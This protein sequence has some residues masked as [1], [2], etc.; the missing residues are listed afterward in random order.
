MREYQDLNAVLARI[1]S[2]H[3]NEVVTGRREGGGDE[4]E[5][6]GMKGRVW[7]RG[8]DLTAHVQGGTSFG[9]SVRIFPILLPV[10]GLHGKWQAA[11]PL[12]SRI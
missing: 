7:G 4:G 5:G 11:R 6:G 9:K 1:Y 10:R 2:S 3:S 8:S 12:D